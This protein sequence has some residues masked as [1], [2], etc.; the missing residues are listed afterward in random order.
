MN[1][2]GSFQFGKD[3]ASLFAA[4]GGIVRSGHHRDGRRRYT[5]SVSYD[6]LPRAS[7]IVRSKKRCYALMG[8]K[9]Q[10]GIGKDE[11]GYCRKRK[12]STETTFDCRN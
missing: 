5:Q 3:E 2:E 6:I 11:R 10:E 8:K 1:D 4:Q 12:V 9:G 7:P